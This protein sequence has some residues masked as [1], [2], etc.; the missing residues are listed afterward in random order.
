MPDGIGAEVGSGR[1]RR[2][3]E[4][5]F[6]A[7]AKAV[8]EAA[9]EVARL[10]G[11][12]R[13]AA[14]ELRAA[15]EAAHRV[16][17]ITIV[18]A[19]RADDAGRELLFALVDDPLIRMLFS[20]HGII[21]TDAPA[22]VGASGEHNSSHAG[23]ADHKH[24]AGQHG[25]ASQSGCGC[26]SSAGGG[27]GSSGGCGCGSDA[28]GPQSAGPAIIPLSAIRRRESLDIWPGGAA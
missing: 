15:I 11:A 26:G 25:P 14:E 7:L 12:P 4:P 5:S 18:R 16:G 27:C 20:L 8:D 22:G 6:E 10:E 19:L 13:K 28:G 1:S 23:H 9:A 17:L 3:P 21:R 2:A 24:V